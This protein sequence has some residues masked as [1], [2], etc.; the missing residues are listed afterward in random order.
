MQIDVEGMELDVLDGI[1]DDLWPHIS[2][3]SPHCKSVKRKQATK[4]AVEYCCVTRLYD[5]PSRL[6]SALLVQLCLFSHCHLST[7]ESMVVV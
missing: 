3:A 4:Q 1:D 6:D 7:N 2:Q 5:V